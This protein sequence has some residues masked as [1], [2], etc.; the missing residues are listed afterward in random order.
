M[1]MKLD[2]HQEKILAVV[3]AAAEQILSISHQIHERPELGNQEFFASGLLAETLEGH[4]F[5]V[6]RAFAEMPTAFCACKGSGEGPVVAFLAEYDA[7]P[8]IGHGCGHNIIA[9]SALAAGIGL[10]SVVEYVPGKVWV[11]GTPAEETAGAKV[12][13]INGGYF[14]GVDAAIMIH[15]F[16]GNYMA[17]EALAL[18]ARKVAFYGRPSHAAAAPW[19]GVNALDALIML[20][21]SLNALRQQIR[22]DARI[23][24]IITKGGSAPN[25]IPEHTEGLFYI[26]SKHR[27][28]QDELLTK[29]RNCAQAAALAT[30]CRFEI[31]RF[32]EDFDNMVNNLP[33]AER[34]RDYMVE[35]LGSGP[36]EHSPEHFGSSDIGNV[37]HVVP[38][39]HLMI[40]IAQ[41]EPCFPHTREFARAA[42]SPYADAAI[43]RA[44]KGMALTGYDVFTKADLLQRA[45]KQLAESQKGGS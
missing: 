18:S 6:Q 43:L 45:R 19:E 11:I 30:G 13:M 9:T 2:A 31:E 40:D 16:S 32:E 15:P 38:A 44:G 17:A 14:E 35:A 10:G 42:V 3:D 33:L 5:M 37:S 24:G 29:F 21:N 26:R 1:K 12:H 4:G 7:L 25:I 27:H 36:F 39:I 23:H 41:G 22:S 8:E 28:Y 34:M 20:F